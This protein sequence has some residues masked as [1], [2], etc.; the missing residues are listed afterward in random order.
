[1]NVLG[2]IGHNSTDILASVLHDDI[3]SS[4]V[5]GQELGDVVYVASVRDVT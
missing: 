1:M 3:I 5:I 4:R 2:L